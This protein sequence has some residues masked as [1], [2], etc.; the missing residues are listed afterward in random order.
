MLNPADESVEGAEFTR[1]VRIMATLRSPHGCPW[2]REQTF[3]SL[4]HYV[5]E[6]AY[7]VVDAIERGD[8]DALREE[9]GDHIFEGVFLAQ[10]ASDERA[11][12]VADALRAVSD[13]L[14]RRHPHVFKDDGAVHDAAS[15]E[16]APSATAALARWDAQKA[17]ERVAAGQASAALGTLPRSL[18]SLLRAYKIGKR[19]ASANFDWPHADEVIGKMEE[20]VRELRDTLRD[21]PADRDRAEEEMGDFLFAIANLSRKLGIEPEAALRKANDKFSRRFEAM[22]RRIVD[23]GRSLSA[24]SL[25]D[26][27]REWQQVKSTE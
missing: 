6:E 26:L 19:A 14:V 12:T 10:I 3:A 2:D 8:L 5:L 21:A 9:I 4:S 16:R 1:L 11:F 27:E 7:E 20:E 17:E 23:S 22:E 24:S 13:K 15:K 18:P 25:D